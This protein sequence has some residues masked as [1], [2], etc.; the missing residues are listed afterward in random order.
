MASIPRTTLE[1][2]HTAIG[3]YIVGTL[4]QVVPAQW[5][6]DQ[7]S[8]AIAL[9]PCC[10]QMDSLQLI[11][12]AD[13][14]IAATCISD[15][16]CGKR[17]I[18]KALR[19]GEPSLGLRRK[20][21]AKPKVDYSPV[22]YRERWTENPI[23]DAW[24][25]VEH[26]GPKLLLITTPGVF[27]SVY[28]LDT[29]TGIWR[30]SPA[31]FGKLHCDAARESALNAAALAQDGMMPMSKSREFQ[32]WARRTQ[33]VS[34]IKQCADLTHTAYM[35]M[36]E[37]E[38]NVQVGGVTTPLGLDADRRYLGCGNGIVDLDT[39][40]LLPFDL[41]SAKLITR[42]TG[43]D[44]D[45]D[46]SD[47][48]ID[49]LL[50]HL[51][52]ED[53]SYILDAAAYALRGNPMRWYVLAGPTQAGKTTFL[54]AVSAALGSASGGGYAFALSGNS[55]LKDKIA[56]ANAH[57]D[58]LKHFPVGRI[59]VGNELADNGM[60]FNEGLIKNLTG[61]GEIDVR[62]V[63]QPS[64][65]SAPATSTIFLAVNPKDL[66][67][68]SLMEEAL[69]ARTAILRWPPFPD[70]TKKDA[71][72]REEVKRP[73]A[74][75]AMLAQLVKRARGLQ[76]PPVM[77]ESVA[78][79]VAEKRR[80][81]I[82]VVGD[83]LLERVRITGDRKDYVLPDALWN[84]V[85]EDLGGKDDKIAGLDRRATL[86]LL[87]EVVPG[88]PPQQ[89]RRV[90]GRKLNAY[91]GVKLLDAA[92]AAPRLCVNCIAMG[93]LDTDVDLTDADDVCPGCGGPMDEA[94]VP[95]VPGGGAHP[96]GPCPAC[97]VLSGG[98][99]FFCVGDLNECPAS[100]CPYCTSFWSAG[101]R[102]GLLK[103]T[104]ALVDSL[105]VWLREHGLPQGLDVFG[106]LA[107]G[108][109]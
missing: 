101:P 77:P 76:E 95:G 85:Y 8:S 90:K 93:V 70:G 98:K 92:E 87:R 106:R 83:W 33:S 104:I 21:P 56:S 44:Y 34:G 62:G 20:I 64:A 107:P 57:S 50:A 5:L 47:H 49:S 24:R 100:G 29:E 27:P 17:K 31:E 72:R 23:G 63:G 10:G 45:P 65:H 48:L 58:H 25:I 3:A 94:T 37:S 9:C 35:Q 40:E 78:S 97:M 82:G 73:S 53:A 22:E 32:T 71:R 46:A 26:S 80:E 28:V 14:S 41:A 96:A 11:P 13:G 4:G 2:A 99:T 55:L 18:E 54:N 91:Q 38:H 6:D 16:A 84:K 102:Q 103:E 42:S 105:D 108:T 36:R 81:S 68:L 67:R 43:V 69:A 74:A 79:A 60:G 75:M 59:A 15:A 86:A 7:H 19:E 61:G 1:D 30:N 51:D 66:M 88:L 89:P 52:S 12:Q 109:G 39:G